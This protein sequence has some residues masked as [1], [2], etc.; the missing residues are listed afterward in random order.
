MEILFD[1]RPLGRFTGFARFESRPSTERKSGGRGLT[2]SMTKMTPRSQVKVWPLRLAPPPRIDLDTEWSLASQRG[3]QPLEKKNSSGR[4]GFDRSKFRV[5]TRAPPTSNLLTRRDYFTLGTFST[6]EREIR[7]QK[8]ELC[9]LFTLGLVCSHK[10][11]FLVYVTRYS[12]ALLSST[13]L[14]VANI[15]SQFALLCLPSCV[16]ICTSTRVSEQVSVRVFVHVCVCVCVCVCTGV[17][18]G[19][20]VCARIRA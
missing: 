17:C 8:L 7:G 3:L 10:S 15:W 5:K 4:I 12:H 20:W 11:S 13:T 9:T 18:V 6:F 1:G 19:V 16:F 14:R 2:C